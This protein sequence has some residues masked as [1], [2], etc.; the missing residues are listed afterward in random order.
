M[1]A[2]LNL[3]GSAIKN[4][5]IYHGEKLILIAAVLIMFSFAYGAITAKPIDATMPDQIKRASNDAQQRV[6]DTPWE[7]YKKG[8]PEL[9]LVDYKGPTAES[10]KPETAVA[11]L[12]QTV[13][14]LPPIFADLVKRADPKIFPV[15]ELIGVGTSAIVP[16][17]R[18]Q[19]EP[20][21]APTQG[22]PRR[23]DDKK[24]GK[25]GSKTGTRPGIGDEM[26]GRLPL[27]GRP[28]GRGIEDDIA[29][30]PGA[31]ATDRTVGSYPL[32]GA[33]ALNSKPEPKYMAIIVGLVPFTEQYNE[34]K[35]RFE[36]ALGKDVT[37]STKQGSDQY[38]PS[39]LFLR[40]QRAEVKDH[41]DQVVEQAW[42]TLDIPAAWKD[43]ELWAQ[44][45][46]Q[47]DP[48]IDPAY[49]FSQMQQQENDYVRWLEWPLPPVFLKNWGF[50]VTHPKVPFYKPEDIQAVQ[51][52]EM[53][54]PLNE[55]PMGQTPTP[56]NPGIRGGGIGGRGI[57]PGRMMGPGGFEGGMR[58]GMRGGLGGMRGG[59]RGGPFGGEMGQGMSTAPEVPY[60]LYRY[61][62]LTCE[63]GKR[64]RYRVQLVLNNPNYLFPA[65]YLERPES[66]NEKLVYSPWS[67]PT[68]VIEIPMNA[69]V[70]PTSVATQG[71]ELEANINMLEITKWKKPESKKPAGAAAAAAPVDL[72][73]PGMNMMNSEP[74]EGYVEVLKDQ[75]LPLGGVAHF[76]NVTVEKV[77]DMMVEIEKKKMEG[78]TLDAQGVMLLD[79]RN[80]N[81]LG[82]GKSS[83][84]TEM[85]FF[86]RN[87]RL[88]SASSAVGHLKSEDYK[89]RT[90]LPENTDGGPGMDVF[91]P[92]PRGMR[93]PA[94]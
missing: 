71:A 15:A 28:R 9:E 41:R 55:N 19:L 78:L 46:Q 57:G 17:T 49:S 90:Y 85:I 29:A 35:K 4:F 94:F 62:D 34:Y 80:D 79:M 67:E 47:N 65:G 37:T 58:G 74:T 31:T 16:Y 60:K 59:M 12:N 22:P 21:A 64:Y 40:I 20:A 53:V 76:T 88:I 23:R 10:I 69:Q 5:F 42:K 91:G 54:D 8:K 32:P 72:I 38:T 68:P 63:K 48:P 61:V 45:S 70:L 43:W 56:T 11:K 1:K 81:P 89:D 92:G 87:G 27:G 24:G 73:G 66:S 3:N 25:A 6:N 82:G 36:D 39:Y 83:G 33:H 77:V 75:R 2:K 50:E 51:E 7:E 44:S 18:E 13:P 26:E 93:R 52:G 14:Y 84:P 30:Q 86:D